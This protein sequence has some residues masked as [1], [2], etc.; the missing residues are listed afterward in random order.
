MK[1]PSLLKTPSHRRFSIQPRYYD[2][3]KEEIEI[4]I[5]RI[6]RTMKIKELEKREGNINSNSSIYGS[7]N[8]NSYYKNQ[9]TGKLRFAILIGL[10]G[11]IGGYFF[12][13]NIALYVVMG[14]AIIIY[15]IRKFRKS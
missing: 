8:R 3:V 15:L 12:L 10:T 5:D 9:G 1:F 11:T 6:K 14:L 4:R 13:G 7:F 2:P